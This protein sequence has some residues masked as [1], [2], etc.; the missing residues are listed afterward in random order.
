MKTTKIQDLKN[1]PVVE[2]QKLLRESRERLQILKF[3]LTAG[4]VKNVKEIKDLKKNI[5]R[6]ITFVGQKTES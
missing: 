5:A 4:K 1:K 2:L 6:I 3:D